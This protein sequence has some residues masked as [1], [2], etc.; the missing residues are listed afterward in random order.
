MTS[1]Y[2]PV[3]EQKAWRNLVEYG[4][5][6]SIPSKDYTMSAYSVKLVTE[7]I[8]GDS[9]ATTSKVD[10]YYA[11]IRI[12]TLKDICSKVRE[13]SIRVM[14]L[15]SSMYSLGFVLP[16]S[17]KLGSAWNNFSY[18][19]SSEYIDIDH[20]YVKLIAHAKQAIAES[21]DG[22]HLFSKSYYN[23]VS[24][25]HEAFNYKEVPL[26]EISSTLRRVGEHSDGRVVNH[27][28]PSGVPTICVY[29]ATP[30]GAQIYDVL[31]RVNGNIVSI[32]DFVSDLNLPTRL[33]RSADYVETT[34]S[35]SDTRYKTFVVSGQLC[36]PRNMRPAVVKFLQVNS[37]KSVVEQLVE[38]SWCVLKS[39]KYRS[40]KRNINLRNIHNPGNYLTFIATNVSG[41]K[42]NGSLTP[43]DLSL[44]LGQH[45]SSCGFRTLDSNDR[46]NCLYLRAS[47]VHNTDIKKTVN[48]TKQVMHNSEFALSGLMF[49]TANSNNYFTRLK[50]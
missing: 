36:I 7:T 45:L 24:V 48:R 10:Y 25:F 13:G 4:M 47:A 18:H 32:L 5:L 6:S 23:A 29:K 14:N 1:A 22:E 21:P 11:R 27:A 49:C 17:H 46:K 19:N 38:G 26:K 34:N 37:V 41:L 35:I 9:M 28:V 43:I 8:T 2:V 50:P 16:K 12:R 31:T 3:M 42:R 15:V 39:E 40:V 20:A 30:N 44:A 33:S